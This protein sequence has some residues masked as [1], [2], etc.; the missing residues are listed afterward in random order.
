[1]KDKDEDYSKYIPDS[2]KISREEKYRQQ[3][4]MIERVKYEIS[5]VAKCLKPCL[6]HMSTSVVFES[7]SE[8]LTNCTAKN[9][10]TLVRF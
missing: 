1:M 4:L 8:C 6:R 7:E 10:E 5:A 9:L 3:F 2:Y